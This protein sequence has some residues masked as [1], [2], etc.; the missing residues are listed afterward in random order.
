MDPSASRTKE[1]QKV[2]SGSFPWYS[3]LL[4]E[5]ASWISRNKTLPVEIAPTAG[6]LS[7]TEKTIGAQNP[8]PDECAHPECK[9]T[10]IVGVNKRFVCEDHTDW[11]LKPIGEIVRL[12]KDVFYES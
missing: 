10:P 1:A 2:S 5:Q 4:A 8:F 7:M 11:V 3:A 6:N 9:K 12:V